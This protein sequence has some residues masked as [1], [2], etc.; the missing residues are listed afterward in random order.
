MSDGT[1]VVV[2]PATPAAPAPVA[3]PATPAAP[4]TP[5]PVVVPPPAK[6][7]DPAA[8]Q[9]VPRSRL[10]EESAKVKAL[11]AEITTLRGFKPE[12]LQADLARTRGQLEFARVGV[13]DEE[14][15]DAVTLAFGKLPAE[16]RPASAVEFWQQITTGAVQAPRTLLGFMGTAATPATPAATPAA[17]RLPASPASPPAAAPTVSVEQVIAAQDRFRAA[18]T[19]ENK[20]ALDT[21]TAAF[22]QRTA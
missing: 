18:P 5:A 4:A 1:P 7:P 8:T 13:L 22:R 2:P 10:N 19:P 9:M 11:E 15:I 20:K 6:K 21:I 12:Q 14:H 17:P 3:T 16:G